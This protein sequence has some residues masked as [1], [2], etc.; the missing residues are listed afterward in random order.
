MH[1]PNRGTHLVY[2]VGSDVATV[3]RHCRH[4]LPMAGITAVHHR[5]G[6]EALLRQLGDRRCVSGGLGVGRNGHERGRN[7]VDTRVRDEVGVELA[8]VDVEGAR[9]PHGARD[10]GR[11]LRDHAVEVDVRGRLQP[12]VLGAYFVNGFVI[13]DKRDVCV[14][15]GWWWCERLARRIRDETTLHTH[16]RTPARRA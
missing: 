9:E 16:R 4:V 14:R 13:E 7:V 11:A 2:V 10:G 15:G 6:H 3:A 8:K 1:G 12:E 5:G